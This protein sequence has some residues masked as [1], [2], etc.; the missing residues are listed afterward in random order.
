[1]GWGAGCSRSIGRCVEDLHLTLPRP[2]Q[3]AE[4]YESV[5]QI[6]QGLWLQLDGAPSLYRVMP[7]G[8]AWATNRTTLSDSGTTGAEH[9]SRWCSQDRNAQEFM[10]VG[11]HAE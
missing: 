8:P 6:I 1:M 3:Q 5:E 2:R 11:I 7:C 4:A 9:S 10:L